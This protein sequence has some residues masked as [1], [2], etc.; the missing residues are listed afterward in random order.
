M[1]WDCSLNFIHHIPNSDID[2]TKSSCVHINWHQKSWLCCQ[3]IQVPQCLKIHPVM[4][5]WILS[6]NINKNYNDKTVP[7][8]NRSC[9]RFY[10]LPSA[11]T[12]LKPLFHIIAFSIHINIKQLRLHHP[13]LTQAYSNRKPITHAISHTKCSTIHKKTLYSIQQSTIYFIQ[14]QNSSQSFSINFYI[15]LTIHQTVNHLKG[16]NKDKVHIHTCIYTLFT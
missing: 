14:S 11:F 9:F 16:D 13:S 10:S 5:F 12:R 1:L 7:S 15:Y 8:A 6:K 2:L 4:S 3:N